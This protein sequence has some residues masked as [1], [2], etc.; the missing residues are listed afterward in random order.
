MLR[1]MLLSIALLSAMSVS[2]ASASTLKVVAHA[3]PKILDP[4]WSTNYISRNHGYMIY[5]TLFATDEKGEIHPQMA[6]GYKVSDDRLTYTITLRD[7]LTWHD[8]P[9]VTTA[10]VIPSIKRW[11]SVDRAGRALLGFVKDIVPVDEKTFQ[12]ILNAPFGHVIEVLGKGDA[13]VPFIMP[14]RVAAT[15]GTEQ[16]KEYVGSGPFKLALNEWKPGEKIVYLK[17]QSYKPRNEPPSGFAGGKIAYVDRVEW[18]TM[19]DQFTAVNALVAG[20]VDIIEALQPDLFPIVEG[21]EDIDL[22]QW[23]EAGLQSVLRFNHVQPPFDNVDARRAVMYAIQQD[24]FMTAQHGDARFFRVCNDPL[25][26]EVGDK[27]QFGDLLIKPDVAKARALLKESGY[28]GAPIAIL[29]QTDL[30]SS[31]KMAPV[32][33]NVL[34]SVGFTVDVQSMDS[35][36]YFVRRN[37]RGPAS[38]GGWNIFFTVSLMTNVP[39]PMYNIFTDASCDKA[40]VGWMC[41]PELEKMRRAFEVADTPESAKQISNDISKRIVDQAH[42]VPMGIYNVFGAYRNDRVS[43]WLKAPA[44]VFWNI[45]K[46]N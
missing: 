39:N 37:N 9:A 15:P 33:S 8:G 7:G 13:N 20:E 31:N 2:T 11:A 28:S 32:L 30:I 46:E 42:F 36:T 22:F 41:D 5:D 21:K 1:K 34:S 24:M 38:S 27:G 12:I 44:A 10:D 25:G 35:Q 6:E 16:I 19:P 3:D 29:H 4:I 43:G 40:F 26:C 45:K 17:N 14:A 18:V 23:N